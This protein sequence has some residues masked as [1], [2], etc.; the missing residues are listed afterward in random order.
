MFLNPFDREESLMLQAFLLLFKVVIC[1]LFSYIYRCVM[2]ANHGHQYLKI[3]HFIAVCSA[4][5]V[6]LQLKEQKKQ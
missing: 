1:S 5:I 3:Q 2:A 6:Y 4:N